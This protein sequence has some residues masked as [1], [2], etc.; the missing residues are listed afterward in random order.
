MD[1]F[2]TLTHLNCTK[3]NGFETNILTL[4]ATRPRVDRSF[5]DCPSLDATIIQTSY[6][7]G[8]AES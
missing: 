5:D 6:S 8:S 3:I 7:R 4:R 1:G 2:F